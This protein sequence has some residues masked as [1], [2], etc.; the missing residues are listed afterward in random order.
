M[1]E[2]LA[3]VLW[4]LGGWMSYNAF[5][6]AGAMR[7]SAGTFVSSMLFWPLGAAVSLVSCDAHH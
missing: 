4:V 1:A 6:V 2:G 7:P 5:V 3:F